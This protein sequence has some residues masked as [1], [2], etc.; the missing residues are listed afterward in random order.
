MHVTVQSPGSTGRA[1]QPDFLTHGFFPAG[2][3]E[4]S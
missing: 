2:S 1:G 4:T 3:Q